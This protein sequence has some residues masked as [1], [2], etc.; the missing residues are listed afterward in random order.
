MSFTSEFWQENSYVGGHGGG[1]FQF[2]GQM[3]AFVKRIRVYHGTSKWGSSGKKGF[4]AGFELEYSDGKLLSHGSTDPSQTFEECRIDVNNGEKIKEMS[5]YGEGDG[6]WDRTSL[7]WFKTSKDQTFSAGLKLV[8][9]N[10]YKMDVGSGLLIGFQG[11]SWSVIDSLKPLFLKRVA[12]QYIDKVTYPTLDL[13]DTGFL[14]M[15]YLQRA[16]SMWN[17]SPYQVKVIGEIA[18][19]EETM[20]N[21]KI[22]VDVGVSVEISAGP[23]TLATVKGTFSLQVGYEHTWQTTKSAERKVRWEMTKEMTCAEDEFELIATYSTGTMDLEYKGT[24]NVMT[25]DGRK[26]SFPTSGTLK[27]VIVSETQYQVRRFGEDGGVETRSLEEDRFLGENRSLEE[28]DHQAPEPEE[29]IPDDANEADYG[30]DSG[31]GYEQGLAED[32]SLAEEEALAQDYGDAADE[33]SMAQPGE[34]DDGYVDPEYGN[35]DVE[36]NTAENTNVEDQFEEGATYE[37]TYD[38]QEGQDTDNAEGEEAAEPE[39]TGEFEDQGDEAAGNGNAEEEVTK[40]GFEGE[41]E[42]EA[43]VNENEVSQ[44]EDYEGDN[45]V[46]EDDEYEISDVD[47]TPEVSWGQGRGVY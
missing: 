42:M 1:D 2:V 44:S 17:G 34:D 24:Y 23:P 46:Q 26:F 12:K 45:E 40:L 14:E 19:K 47:G 27:H 8:S 21:N 33:D 28:A 11:R 13:N 9:E 6:K 41:A 25:E 7:L 36:E 35:T 10:Q 4:L 3:G 37:D 5:L 16:K 18:E 20:W 29:P 38:N 39:Y 22:S 31:G 43:A 15:K 32:E 30:D